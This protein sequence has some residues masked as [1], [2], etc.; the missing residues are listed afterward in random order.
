MRLFAPGQRLLSRRSIHSASDT[1]AVLYR[2]GG[3][4]GTGHVEALN[5]DWRHS[6]DQ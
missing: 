3:R 5:F 2:I 4:Q 6:R 1:R